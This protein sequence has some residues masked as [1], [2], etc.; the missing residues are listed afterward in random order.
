MLNFSDIKIGSIVVFNGKPCVVIKC[1]FVKMQMAKPVKKCML[2]DISTG[3]N[4]PNTYNSG[5]SIQEGDLQKMEATFLYIQGSEMVFMIRDTYETVELPISLLDDKI[6]YL[7]EGLEVT[8]IY[9]NEVAVAVELPIKIS[10]KIIYAEEAVRGNTVS[11]VLKEV[12]IETGKIIKVPAF[13]K[14]GDYILVN[15]VEDEY[16]ERDTTR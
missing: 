8:I 2:K 6:D 9:F 7:S 11:G 14:E 10:Y 5:D 13:I 16:V 4:Y 12:K 3:S 15:T 1:S